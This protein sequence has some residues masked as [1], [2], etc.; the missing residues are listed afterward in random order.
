MS[1]EDRIVDLEIRLTHQD[2]TID[3]LNKTIFEQW[4][5]IDQLTKDVH[6]L[7]E[8]LKALTPS[9]IDDAPYIPP[10]Y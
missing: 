4:Q 7:K 8:R 3:D 9:E 6:S 5:V 1:V 2:N 10:H